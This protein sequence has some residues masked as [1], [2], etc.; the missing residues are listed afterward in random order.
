MG[1]LFILINAHDILIQTD[2]TLFK[3]TL[4]HFFPKVEIL[5]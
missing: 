2:D 1:I 5:G 4:V 3:P